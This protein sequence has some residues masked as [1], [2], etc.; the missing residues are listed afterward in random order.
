MMT[1]MTVAL[2]D[3]GDDGTAVWQCLI[4]DDLRYVEGRIDDTVVKVYEMA[5]RA[6][7]DEEQG[8]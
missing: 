2:W 1:K 3:C 4:A 8:A 6:Y 7:E 5:L